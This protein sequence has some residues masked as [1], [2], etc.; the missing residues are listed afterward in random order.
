MIYVQLILSTCTLI[1]YRVN[2]TV[3]H[4]HT[5]IHFE[6]IQDAEI[7]MFMYMK[8]QKTDKHGDPILC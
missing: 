8:Y 4:I 2:D 1:R 5:H 6:H 7:Y 3:P